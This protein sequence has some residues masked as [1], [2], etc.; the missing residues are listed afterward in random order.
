MT[1]IVTLVGIVEPGV[2]EGLVKL[3]FPAFDDF[4]VP[5]AR[6]SRPVQPVR[7]L[8]SISPVQA[9]DDRP[10]TWSDSAAR[11]DLYF[12]F[13]RTGVEG[14]DSLT[15]TRRGQENQLMALDAVV[16]AQL[17]FL[18]KYLTVQRM[19]AGVEP[20]FGQTD[21]LEFLRREAAFFGP[22]LRDA[23]GILGFIRLPQHAD[24]LKYLRKEGWLDLLQAAGLVTPAHMDA[25][26][27]GLRQ[28]VRARH[29]R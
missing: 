12:D 18:F 27:D 3:L 4:S 10:F 1:E 2:V 7:R 17:I 25:F 16:V 22:C 14:E 24:V 6:A 9:S 28:A 5:V 26:R 23:R 13:E 29:T 21:I 8:S 20:L 19:R 15:V 11:R